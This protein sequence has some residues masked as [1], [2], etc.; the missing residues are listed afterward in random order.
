MT[1]ACLQISPYSNPNKQNKRGDQAELSFCITGDEEPHSF[2]IICT[3]R[4]KCQQIFH[5]VLTTANL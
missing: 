2:L 4:K 3:K 5:H 1:A